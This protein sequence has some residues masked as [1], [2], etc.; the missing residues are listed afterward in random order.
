M[1]EEQLRIGLIMDKVCV[2]MKEA[3]QIILNADRSGNYIDEKDGHA[4]FVTLYD[5]K[6]E[7]LLRI[8]LLSILPEAKFIGEEGE[9]DA[10]DGIG[11]AFIVDPIDGTTNFIRDYKVSV[12]SVGL[13]K[14]GE[15]VG[16]A[17]YNPYLDLMYTAIKGCGA[18]R[19]GKPIHVSSNTLDK[20]IVLFGTATY[21]EEYAEVTF[22]NAYELYKKSL[23]VRRS[24]SAATDLC[25][26]AEGSADMYFEMRLSPWDFAA[27]TLIV[28]E[29]GGVVTGINGEIVDISKPMGILATNGKIDYKLKL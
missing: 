6:V 2:A 18:K 7:D 13:I 14:D 24:G 10:F 27:G 1:T 20:A 17:I 22:T 8:G 9:S 16:G 12:I 23:D 15:R 3:A 19:N 28:E 11:Y 5:K 4:N 26:I 29:A 21:Y 25:H